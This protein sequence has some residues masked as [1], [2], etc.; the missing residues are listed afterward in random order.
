MFKEK[1][2]TRASRGGGG[3]VKKTACTK[4]YTTNYLDLF[5]SF[6]YVIWLNILCNQFQ[7]R[8]SRY[9]VKLF[10]VGAFFRYFVGWGGGGGGGLLDQTIFFKLIELPI[11]QPTRYS[12]ITSVFKTPLKRSL[13]YEYPFKTRYPI[14][15]VSHWKIPLR[16]W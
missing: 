4:E 13:C 11:E 6:R 15:V 14:L 1:N 3:G 16:L 2:T 10:F 7:G 8:L 5:L 12:G 9:L